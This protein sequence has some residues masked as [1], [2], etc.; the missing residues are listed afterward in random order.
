MLCI[1]ELLFSILNAFK[2]SSHFFRVPFNLKNGNYERNCVM[3]TSLHLKR[4]IT[5]ER[6][7]ESLSNMFYNTYTITLSIYVY[8]YEYV[9]MYIYSHS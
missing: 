2:F 1:T 8:L 5:V 3:N 6:E 9:N 7:R 4:N